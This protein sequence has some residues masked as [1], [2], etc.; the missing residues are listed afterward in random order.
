MYYGAFFHS[1]VKFNCSQIVR[2]FGVP[3]SRHSK[4]TMER[5]VNGGGRLFGRDIPAL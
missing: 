1:I 4:W 2:I 3:Y 5:Q